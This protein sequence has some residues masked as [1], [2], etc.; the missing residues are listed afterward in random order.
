MCLPFMMPTI[1]ITM[2]TPIPLITETVP[3]IVERRKIN[4]SGPTSSLNKKKKK[5]GLANYYDHF[6]R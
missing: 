1:R 4:T 3:N 5:N 2:T 6:V